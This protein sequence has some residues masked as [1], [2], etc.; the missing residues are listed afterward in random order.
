MAG[1]G[2]AT[3]YALPMTQEQLADCVGLTPVH[4]NRTLKTLEAE[5]LIMRRSSRAIVIGDWNKLAQAGDFDSAY[6]HLRHRQASL[7]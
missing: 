7:A 1:L 6:L 2:D 5:G 3:D 4:V